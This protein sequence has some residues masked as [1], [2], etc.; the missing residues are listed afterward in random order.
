M[1][2]VTQLK[3]GD[4]VRATPHGPV[5]RV[6]AVR[7]GAVFPVVMLEGMTEPAVYAPNATLYP[8]PAPE[9]TC[10]DC[11]E[12]M[13]DGSPAHQRRCT[14]CNVAKHLG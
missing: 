11:G 13:R 9:R 3:A 4:H 8:A 6:L 14:S 12:L 5:R 1:I 2:P 7:A 10:V